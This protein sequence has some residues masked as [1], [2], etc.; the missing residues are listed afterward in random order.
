MLYIEYLREKSDLQNFVSIDCITK[1][2][3]FLWKYEENI[4]K[5]KEMAR[6]KLSDLK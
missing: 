1:S 6:K 2:F 5:D 3:F 4:K